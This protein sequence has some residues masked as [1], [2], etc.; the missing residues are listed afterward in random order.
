MTRVQLHGMSAASAHSL[1]G[2]C[3]V[4]NWRRRSDQRN[5]DN[6]RSGRDRLCEAARKCG[7]GADRPIATGNIREPRRRFRET[8]GLPM[9]VL[10]GSHKF[11]H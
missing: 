1:T 5:G 7:R 4:G 8:L 9:A 11:Q 6:H 2:L 3:V 10:A